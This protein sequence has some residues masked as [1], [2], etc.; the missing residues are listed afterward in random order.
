MKNHDIISMTHVVQQL[1]S[2]PLS[3]PHAIHVAVPGATE[4]RMP[5]GTHCHDTWELFCPLRGSLRFVTAGCDP[6]IIPSRHLLIVPP[7]CLHVTVSSLTQP[8]PL[9]LAVMNLP[10]TRNPYGGL[11]IG[12]TTPKTSTTLSPLELAAWASRLGFAPENM[13]EQVIPAIQAGPWG[14]ERALGMLRVLV[15]AYAEVITD[16]RQDPPSREARR[17]TEAQ[18]HLQSHY[19][20]AKLSVETVATAIGLSASHLGFIFRKS[21]GHTLHQ[22]LIELRLRRATDLLIRTTLSIKEIA[23]LT[24][25]SNQFYFCAAFKKRHRMAPST[26][27]R[28]NQVVSRTVMTGL[29]TTVRGGRSGSRMISSRRSQARRA[30]S[31]RSISIRATGT[32]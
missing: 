4:G 11:S 31:C 8:K 6:I 9:A 15:A 26:F 12:S 32:G 22:A 20:E 25:W 21:T 13:M 28:S 23:A 17:I 14:R 19:C 10:S 29:K 18:L 30:H 7:G 16:S 1:L 2:E 24:G 5:P 27:R 3:D